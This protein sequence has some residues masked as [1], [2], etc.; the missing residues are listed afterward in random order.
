M[1]DVGR[2]LVLVG[3]LLAAIGGL[4]WIAGRIPGL[5]RLPGDFVIR[6]GDFEIHLPLATCAPS[7]TDAASRRRTYPQAAVVTSGVDP[8][9]V[10]AMQSAASCRRST[11]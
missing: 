7:T 8:A 11:A 1:S 9:S 3:L 5:G 6:R 10:S 4:L 2:M